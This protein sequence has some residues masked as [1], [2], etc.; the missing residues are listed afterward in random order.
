MEFVWRTYGLGG[1][2]GL[3]THALHNHYAL[4]SF[5]DFRSEIRIFRNFN[6]TEIETSLW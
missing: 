1:S 4:P 2:R 5:L 3:L 6:L